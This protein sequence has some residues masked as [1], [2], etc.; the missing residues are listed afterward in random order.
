[1]QIQYNTLEAGSFGWSDL[2]GAA[3]VQKQK[4]KNQP[5]QIQSWVADTKKNSVNKE[6]HAPIEPNSNSYYET[7]YAFGRVNPHTYIKSRSNR[8]LCHSG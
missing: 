1:M 6:T 7:K 5:Y 3:W 2:R 4:D 8:T